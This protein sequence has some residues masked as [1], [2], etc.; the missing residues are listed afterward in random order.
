MG[1]QWAKNEVVAAKRRCGMLIMKSDGSLAPRGT[2][3]VAIS[4]VFISGVAAPHLVLAV[5]TLTNQRVPIVLA[6][7]TVETVDTGTDAL[8]I[9]A[10]GYETGD[11]PFVADETFGSI[12]AGSFFWI[13]VDDVS[14]VGI[15]TSPANAYAGTR[16]ALT[17]TEDGAT[18]SDTPST[19]RGLDG[20]FVYE[21]TQAETNHDAP[22]TIVVVHSPDSAD[23][24]RDVGA[25]AYTTVEMRAASDDLGAAELEN[26]LSRDDA[27]RIILRY[28]AA[29]F[30]K[31][32]NDYQYRDMADTKDSH[33]GTVTS[34]GR[35]DADID[36]AT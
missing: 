33:H 15:A 34:S 3:F 9:G 6:D 20:H 32:G 30:S 35:V 8:E 29:K 5:G 36:D 25:G 13:I 23:Y 22:E 21:A 12:I 7:K 28:A 10:H 14:H 17:G 18:I 26:G 27:W 4:Y 16:V 24:D 1:A 11:G 19:Q 31:T 2:D